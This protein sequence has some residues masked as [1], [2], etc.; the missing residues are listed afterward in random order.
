MLTGRRVRARPRSY[1]ETE[2]KGSHGSDNS[3]GTQQ[4]PTGPYLEQCTGCSLSNEW[5]LTCST[6]NGKSNV[7][8]LSMCS[9]KP[10][11]CTAFNNVV[12]CEAA[13]G[14]VALNCGAVCPS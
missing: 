1:T 6:C 9:A 5:M 13:S 8:P 14:A 2:G 4:L 7:T 10:D 11:S 3:C 12:V